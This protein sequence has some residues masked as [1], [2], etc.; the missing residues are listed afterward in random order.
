MSNSKAEQEQR[1]SY[2]K[3]KEIIPSIK[4]VCLKCQAE[5]DSDGLRICP[6]CTESNAKVGKRIGYGGSYSTAANSSRKD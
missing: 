3:P 2:K 6:M 4:R 1:R 5:F